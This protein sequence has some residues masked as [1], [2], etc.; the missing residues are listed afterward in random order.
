MNVVG[1]PAIVL[2]C[3]LFGEIYKVL[4]KKNTKKYKIIPFVVAIFGAILAIIIYL[5]EPKVLLSATNVWEAIVIGIVS[6]FSSTGS[7]QAIKQ[8]V[9]SK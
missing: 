5:T 4:F 7:N 8:M 6:G 1:I 9:K 2:L 3:Y